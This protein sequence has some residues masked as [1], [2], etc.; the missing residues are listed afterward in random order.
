MRARAGPS[1]R[2]QFRWRLVTLQ[3]LIL[4]AVVALLVAGLLARGAFD[5]YE[6]GDDV[7]AAVRE[8]A[9]RAPG[10]GIALRRT[11][12]LASLEAGV[13]DLWFTVK[14]RAGHR[15]SHGAVPG[16]FAGIGAALDRVGQARLGWNLGDPPRP[17]ARI[18]WI[19]SP[20]GALQ[21]MTGPGL[22]A[23]WYRL[24][25]SALLLVLL[26]LL[27][28]LAM[29]GLATWLV[30]PVV[31]RSALAGL[32]GAIGE[33][34]RIDI[35]RRGARLPVETV[36]REVRP[37]VDAVNATLARLDEGHERHRRFL[38]DA[39]HELRTP[40]AILTTRLGL[41]PDDPVR[42]RLVEDA[43]R[44]ANLADQLLDLERLRRQGRADM[45]PLDLVALARDVAAD[46][47][48][49]AIGA[50]Y[51]LGLETAGGPV[52]A[53]ADRSSLERA[54]INLVQN[55]IGH[56]GRRGAIV[57]RVGPGTAIEVRDEGPGIPEAERSRM[58][59]PFRRLGAGG[60]GAGLGLNLAGEIVALHGGRIVALDSPGGGL[61]MRIELPGPGAGRRGG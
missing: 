32:D 50:G 29:M 27:P 16:E 54:L 40:I 49:M 23:P 28:I 33:A 34:E 19:H 26:F 13:P 12:A 45:A 7:I 61:C 42:A 44:L 59:E 60:D 38:A 8:A 3:A 11:P 1:L 48:P 56:G 51:T 15:L 25:G 43:G 36:P 4:A 35:E 31:V 46:L 6:P 47:A 9:V 53:L 41:L 18:Q 22:H 17:T 10:G 20:A 21:V 39:A 2:A 52:E 57:V 37:L 30:T 24:V 14:D 5:L 55:A 58:F